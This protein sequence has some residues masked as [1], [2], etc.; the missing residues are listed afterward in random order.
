MSVSVPVPHCF[1]YYSIVVLSEVWECYASNFG[2]FFPLRIALAIMSLL[3]FHIKF[4]FIYSSS[5][6]KFM[7]ILIGIGLNMK[8]A[9]GNM[10]F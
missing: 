2:F 8:I 3:Q 7:G 9:L 10:A 6:K 1:D 4:R 5:V